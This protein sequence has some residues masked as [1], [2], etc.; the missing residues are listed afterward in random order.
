MIVTISSAQLFRS[1]QGTYVFFKREDAFRPNA[2]RIFVLC[3]QVQSFGS[4]SPAFAPPVFR[5]K[6]QYLKVI[7]RANALISSTVKSSEI[8]TPPQEFPFLRESM[9]TY[10]CKPTLSSMNSWIIGV[11]LIVFH[12]RLWRTEWFFMFKKLLQ[13]R[14]VTV[15]IGIKVHALSRFYVLISYSNCCY[16]EVMINPWTQVCIMFYKYRF[17]KEGTESNHLMIIW[18]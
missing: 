11:L 5:F 17:L 9:T 14:E 18:I 7:V 10:A 8:R 3:S 16:E 4:M 1:V 12:H 15:K 2:S 6:K 13:K